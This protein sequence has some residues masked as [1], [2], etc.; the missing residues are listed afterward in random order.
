MKR[1]LQ[2]FFI[3]VFLNHLKYFDCMDVTIQNCESFG[4]EEDQNICLKCKDKYFLFFNNLYCFA[5]NDSYYGQIGCGGN[6]DS[7][8]YQQ[9][10]LVYCNPNEC[11]EGYYYL[12][13]ICFNCSIGSPGCKKCNVTET[14]INTQIDYSY[15]C[16]ECQSNEYK[17]DEFSTCQ[18]CYMRHCQKCHY[19]DNYSKI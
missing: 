16:Q 18:K 14:N 11:K 10:R 19:T 2:I 6:C 1:I 3:V 17:L 12:N 13:G 8:R 4:K 7:S 9:D 15:K 5:C